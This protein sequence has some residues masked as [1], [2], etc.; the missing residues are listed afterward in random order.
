MTHFTIL[1]GG[2]LTPTPRLAGQIAGSRFI[3]ADSGMRHAAALGIVPELWIGDFDSVTPALADA[4]PDVPREVYPAEKDGTDGELAIE[5]A[6]RRGA[7]PL[8]LA[9]AFGGDRADHAI[10]HIAVAMSL[11][12]AGRPVLLSSGDQ[13]GTPLPEGGRIAFDYPAG[14]VFSVVGLTDLAGLT[15]KG[16]QWPLDRA[17]I[18]FGSSLTLSNAVESTLTVALAAGRAMLVAHLPAGTSGK[19]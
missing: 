2:D 18:P 9:G 16:A 1:L 14:T 7:G 3:A 10:F 11:F 19:A 4:W 13:E 8:L 5:A 15:L 12:E 6:I 17:D